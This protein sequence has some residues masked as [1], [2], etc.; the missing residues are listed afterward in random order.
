MSEQSQTNY[1]DQLTPTLHL[2]RLDKLS[3]LLQVGRHNL[4]SLLTVRQSASWRDSNPH[5][6]IPDEPAFVAV[7]DIEATAN[8]GHP[9]LYRVWQVRTA[10]EG[11]RYQVRAELFFH[12]FPLHEDEGVTEIELESEVQP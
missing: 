1:R 2:F 8:L 6:L 9:H 5:H 4:Y 11:Y 10:P 7:L 12:D 3:R